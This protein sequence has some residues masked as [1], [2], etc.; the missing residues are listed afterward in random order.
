[1][2]RGL[3]LF[4][5]L[6]LSLFIITL[7]IAQDN[8][9]VDSA[10]QCLKDKISEDCSTLTSEQQIFSI[11]A[12][13]KYKN[14][15]Q[16]LLSNSN[17]ISESQQCWPKANCE[18]KQTS[19]AILA[20]NKINQDSQ[21][22]ENW[23][24]NQT[25]T[26]SDLL[27]FIQ[28]ESS[29]ATSCSATYNGVS[30]EFEI[31]ED[32]KISSDAGSCLKRAYG[33]YWLQIQPDSSCLNYNYEIS[34]DK[35]FKTTLL[36]KSQDSPTIHVSQIVHDGDAG[37]TNSE[38]VVYQCFKKGGICDY[39]SSLWAVLTLDFLGYEVTNYLPYLE[40]SV[41]DFSTFFPESFLYRVTGSSDYLNIILSNRFNGNFWS[42]GSGNKFY[43]TA[44]AFLSLKNKDYSQITS[45]KE[46]L[47]DPST[48]GNDGCWGTLSDTGFL[49]FTGWPQ[50]FADDEQPDDSDSTSCELSGFYCVPKP[51]DCFDAGGELKN[52]FQCSGLSACCTAPYIPS[53]LTCVQSEGIFCNEGYYCPTGDR[54]YDVSDYALGEC[55]KSACLPDETSTKTECEEN[56]YSCQTNCLSNEETVDYACNFGQVCCK[57]KSTPPGEVE[58]PKSYLW[59]IILIVLILLVLLAILF[60]NRLRLFFF[61]F[62]TKFKSGKPP[63]R[64]Y[65]GS[66]P[67]RPRP[68]PIRPQP[69]YPRPQ[70]QP[71]SR[72][73]PRQSLSPQSSKDKEFED[74]L[75]KLKEMSK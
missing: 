59:I 45:A 53:E 40:A 24:L 74:T 33:D 14:C 55:C 61:K 71:Q 47:S 69:V 25:K 19:L 28:T 51:K 34:C 63:A 20:L 72:P 65:P 11:L 57:T 49:L 56:S 46:Y 70:P 16:A 6:L 66:F 31:G 17:E 21:K 58:P 35:I 1:M 39:E 75:N 38:K 5:V 36:Y 3:K 54:L 10:Y 43:D 41:N 12:L 64:P 62:K 30:Y 68:F 29:E 13:G 9:T 60:R 8:S 52:N 48:Q 67:P 7:V 73:I 37:D 32:K 27:W 15:E 50:V 4:T 44:L 23:L 18:P 22:A 26:A 2:K 42:A